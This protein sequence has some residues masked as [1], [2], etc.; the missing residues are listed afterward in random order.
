[1]VQHSIR[2]GQVA[3]AQRASQGAQPKVLTRQRLP[4]GVAEGIWVARCLWGC[5]PLQ[6]AG[7]VP[8][9]RMCGRGASVTIPSSHAQTPA[10]KGLQQDPQAAV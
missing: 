9:P 2:G 1:M 5:A 3:V 6:P 4:L 8:G 10:E 7:D